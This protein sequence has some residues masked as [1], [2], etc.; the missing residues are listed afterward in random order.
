MVLGV[1]GV[2][3][4]AWEQRPHS[5]F[6]QLMMSTYLGVGKQGKKRQGEG[7]GWGSGAGG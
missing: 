7:R 4:P 1:K 3:P 5:P 2:K 6:F